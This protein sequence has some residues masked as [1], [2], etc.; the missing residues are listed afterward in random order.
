MSE[1]YKDKLLQSGLL[2][3]RENEVEFCKENMLE[4]RR[5]ENGCKLISAQRVIDDER[6]TSI[7]FQ[8]LSGSYSDPKSKEGLH[9]FTEHL[10]FNRELHTL[11]DKHLVSS[12]GGTSSKGIRFI[13]DGLFNTQ[14]PDFG[15]APVLEKSIQTLISPLGLTDPEYF[16]NTKNVIYREIEEYEA[17]AQRQS[18]IKFYESVL[19]PS[20]AD[21]ANTLGTR[22]SLQGI[23]TDDVKALANEKFVA[24][25]MIISQLCLGSGVESNILINKLEEFMSK[26]PRVGD[27]TEYDPF[28]TAKLNPVKPGSLTKKNILIK[29][30]MSTVVV[31][32][33]LDLELYSKEDYALNTYLAKH[34]RNEFFIRSREIG[35]G[36]SVDLFTANYLPNKVILGF[37]CVCKSTDAADS[38]A[39]LHSTCDSVLESISK[40]RDSL[41]EILHIEHKRQQ[42]N[43]IP[44]EAKLGFAIKHLNMFDLVADIKAERD[45]KLQVE[46]EDINVILEKIQN[47][48]IQSYIIGDIE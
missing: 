9:H 25:N 32:R 46:L 34:L 14:F 24:S 48:P 7:N 5:L 29:N 45:I 12:N 37:L 31:T 13:L 6:S 3:P 1:K 19:D 47:T 35:L 27:K 40:D 16:Q 20:N 36:Y 10:L 26:F 39:L 15:L 2:I 18:M 38:L 17:N 43:P 11:H 21:L 28:G 30:G 4:L 23:T 33:T 41:I 42:A 8:I 22:E 44:Q